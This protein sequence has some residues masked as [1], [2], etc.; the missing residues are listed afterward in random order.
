MTYFG[1]DA[2][3]F[4]PVL[5]NFDYLMNG[6]RYL[7]ERYRINWIRDLTSL[8]FIIFIQTVNGILTSSI[9]HLK[10]RIEQAREL[11]LKTDL[12]IA[13]ITYKVGFANQ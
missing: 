13:D 3:V 9:C 4:L 7:L 5:H 12:S 8:V 11:L 10:C 1:I 6:D 2:D